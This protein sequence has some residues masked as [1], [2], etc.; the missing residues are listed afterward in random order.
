MQTLTALN[1]LRAYGR[2]P[3][4]RREATTGAGA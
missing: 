2:L 1:T 4:T 3:D